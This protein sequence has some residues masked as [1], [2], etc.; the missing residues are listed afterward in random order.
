MGGGIIEHLPSD[1]TADELLSRLSSEEERTGYNSELNLYFEDLLADFNSRNVEQINAHLDTIVGA[2][3]R[4]IDG[5]VRLIYGGSVKK[6]TYV[7]G[8]SDVDVLAILNETS[9]ANESPAAVLDYFAGRIQ[10]RLPFTEITRGKLAV[11]VTFSDG[12]QIQ[13]LPAVSTET[14]VRIASPDGKSWSN[15]VRPDSFARKLTEVIKPTL[16]KWFASSN[17]S[18][19]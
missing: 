4:Y 9:L 15:V 2:I 12:H 7:D 1:T 8:L 5:A 16:G 18:K 13:V 17:T 14:G 19:R 3:E 11:T 10:E 6:H